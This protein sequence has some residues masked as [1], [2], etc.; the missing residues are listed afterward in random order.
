[1]FLSIKTLAKIA[2]KLAKKSSKT[3]FYVLEEKEREGVLMQFPVE[4]IWGIGGRSAEKLKR[5]GIKN[6]L[7]LSSMSDKWIR[8]R[9][10]ITG[11]KLV[12]EL[13]GTTYYEIEESTPLRKQIRCSR[14][15]S[16]LYSELP[17]LK[18]AV[19]FYTSRA[20]EK[21]R[22]QGSAAGV[23]TVFLR[24]NRH[25]QDQPQYR[26][27]ASYKL[28]SPTADTFKLTAAALQLLK[29]IYKEDYYYKKAGVVLSE[30]TTASSLQVSFLEQTPYL[31][32]SKTLMESL[33]KINLRWGRETVKLA[34]SGLKQN[35]Q[36][37]REMRSRRFTTCWEEMLRVS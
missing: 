13:R 5:Y 30:I 26:P 28:L 3:G 15:F 21:L 18:E 22:R 32:K 29:T 24:T 19:S 33:D 4:D 6:A 8:E 12:Y 1:M 25:R 37:K 11:L 2:N 17:E 23:L 35:W 9:F 16:S 10:T 7:E 20:A 31:A 34:S 36:M 27:T 14:S